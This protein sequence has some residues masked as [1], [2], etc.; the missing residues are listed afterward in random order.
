M[1]EDRSSKP[2]RQ[3]VTVFR[4]YHDYLSRM[5]QLARFRECGLPLPTFVR[6]R[7]LKPAA[8]GRTI[9]AGHMKHDTGLPGAPVAPVPAGRIPYDW[10]LGG[11][12][13]CHR[14]PTANLFARVP[15]LRGMRTRSLVHNTQASV[16]ACRFASHKETV[17]S[18]T[19]VRTARPM[20]PHCWTQRSVAGR[21]DIRCARPDARG[22]STA[23]DPITIEGYT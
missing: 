8:R 15:R 5:L 12:S 3:A 11:G 23:R 21:L 13:S 2:P 6:S 18:G 4:K 9:V 22:R 1:D 17:A 20:S 16:D 10:M 19:F 14:L 7:G